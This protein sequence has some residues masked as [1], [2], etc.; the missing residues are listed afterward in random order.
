VQWP[1]RVVF[2]DDVMGDAGKSALARNSISYSITIS[3]R[4]DLFESSTLP[5]LHFL[6]SPQQPLRPE[7]RYHDRFAGHLEY[8]SLVVNANRTRLRIEKGGNSSPS[9]RVS[10]IIEEGIVPREDIPSFHAIALKLIS[11]LD[12]KTLGDEVLNPI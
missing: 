10:R 12:R 3:Q 4:N 9:I 11:A 6:T 5:A 2:L 8:A 7:A 1:I